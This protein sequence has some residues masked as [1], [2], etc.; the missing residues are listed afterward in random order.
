M[1]KLYILFFL[2][3]AFAAD[4]VAQVKVTAQIDSAEILIGEQTAVRVRVIHPEELAVSFPKDLSAVIDRNLEVV[5]KGE[6]DELENT[7]EKG[8]KTSVLSFML[9]SF[10]PALYYIPKLNVTVGKKNY[11][12]E[13]LAIKVND[14]AV[15][16]LHVDKFFGPKE[17]IE[18][19]Y[20]WHDWIPVFILS[21][22][23]IICIAVI[24]YVTY[25]V[26]RVKEVK[27][28]KVKKTFVFPHKEAAKEI[29]KLKTLYSSGE[30]SSK[31]Y[32]TEL[33]TILKRYVT[34]RYG[35]SAKEMTSY[36]LVE[37]LMHLPYEEELKLK[38]NNSIKDEKTDNLS[39][40]DFEELREI[41][42]T[43]DLTKFAKLKTDVNE[44][45]MNL[46]RLS[47]YIEA[48]KSETQKTT[49]VLDE[50]S[51]APVQRIKPR[52]VFK[53]VLVLSVLAAIL[54]IILIV[55]EAFELLL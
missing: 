13:Q 35:F 37:H 47:D 44:D 54:V 26:R 18:P 16:T 17:I 53:T 9:T 20:T 29:D 52:L 36:E 6:I 2:V 4:S 48:T 40:P 33:I 7:P 45:R 21:I 41:L 5:N 22:L 51:S 34:S 11:E 55:K 32:Y 3:V 8:M 25:L 49:S 14:V 42:N 27:V 43:A 50:E 31:D 19:V 38:G 28:I 10:E 24:V 30:L 1:R 39:R 15:D 12:T 23:L 46:V